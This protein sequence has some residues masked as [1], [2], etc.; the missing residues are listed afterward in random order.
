MCT[1]MK[2]WKQKRHSLA[3]FRKKLIRSLYYTRKSPPWQS[4]SCQDVWRPRI[5][6]CNRFETITKTGTWTKGVGEVGNN[7]KNESNQRQPRLRVHKMLKTIILVLY[8]MIIN[9]Y[10]IYVY[11]YIIFNTHTYY[12]YYYIYIMCAAMTWMRACALGDVAVVEWNSDGNR[13]YSG[14]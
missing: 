3:Y 4:W 6:I 1:Y 7:N 14:R 13:R 10:Y 2:N 12:I 5:Q 9:A 8:I 11:I